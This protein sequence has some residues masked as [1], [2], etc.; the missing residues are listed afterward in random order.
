MPEDK[1]PLGSVVDG[2]YVPDSE[3]NYVWRHGE[4]P[5]AAPAEYKT[6]LNGIDVKRVSDYGDAFDQGLAFALAY[7]TMGDVEGGKP[8]DF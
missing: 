3:V 5:Q 8:Q 6:K 1:P 4:G 2:A 7:E